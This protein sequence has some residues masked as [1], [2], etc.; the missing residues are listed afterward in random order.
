MGPHVRG[1]TVLTFRPQSTIILNSDLTAAEL[2]YPTIHELVHIHQIHTRQLS[3]SRTGVY[4][5]E[6]STYIVDPQTISYSE[7]MKLPWEVDA[8]HQQEIIGKKLLDN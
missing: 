3:V 4:V 8:F 5:W 7:Y 6:G 1:E 2:F